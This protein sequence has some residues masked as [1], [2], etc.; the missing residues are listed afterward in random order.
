MCFLSLYLILFPKSV[1]ISVH[2]LNH[3]V[4]IA[5]I[6]LFDAAENK[7][8][9]IALKLPIKF[10]WSAFRQRPFQPLENHGKNGIQGVV[11]RFWSEN[12]PVS[13]RAEICH[14]AGLKPSKLARFSKL[15]RPSIRMWRKPPDLGAFF[16]FFA[17]ETILWHCWTVHVSCGWYSMIVR[18]K[19]RCGIRCVCQQHSRKSFPNHSFRWAKLLA[20]KS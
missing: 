7:S 5:F 18:S 15:S 4:L 20:R 19:W 16:R 1:E 8:K 2:D 9:L 12:Y 11:E 14:S 6:V 3:S 17:I 10:S 13:Q